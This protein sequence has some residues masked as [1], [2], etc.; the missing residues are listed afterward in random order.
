MPLIILSRIFVLATVLLAGPA[1]A[2]TV[3]TTSLNFGVIDPLA[4]QGVASTST[5]TVDCTT[6]ASY[7][8]SASAGNGAFDQRYLND[9]QHQLSYNVYTDSG[10]TQVFGD[11]SGISATLSGSGTTGSFT[12]Y[13]YL[14]GQ[15]TAVPGS[16][17]DSLVVTVTY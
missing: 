11:G 13:G 16:Y 1:V 14:P 17:A 7:T 4:G 10:H 6:A 5:V 9:G 8:L 2:C 3:S 12:L 15:P